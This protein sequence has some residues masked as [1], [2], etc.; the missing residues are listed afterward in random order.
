MHI[1]GHI[2]VALLE[3]RLL[4]AYIPHQAVTKPLFLATFFPDIIDKS[5][6]YLFHWMPNGRHYS[7][8]LF[9]LV[10]FSGF[11]TLIWGRA[12]GFTW[13]AGHL[14][15]LL[16]DTSPQEKMPWFFP[17][18]KYAFVKGSLR[19]RFKHLIKESV[20]LGVVIIL[21]RLSR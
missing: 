17:L 14:C 18:K 20:L 16:A 2:A 6:G 4:S 12:A 5:I 8:N 10:L 15:H 19:F 1:P 13:F 21:L 7:H 3:H 9:S 11:I